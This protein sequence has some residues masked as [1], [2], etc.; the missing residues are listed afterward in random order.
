LR[1]RPSEKHSKNIQKIRSLI[2]DI[3]RYVDNI[4][5]IWRYD[6]DELHKFFI[7]LNNQHINIH[8]IIEENGKLPF[9]DVLVSKKTD[10]RSSSTENQY[11]D[12]YL[13]AEYHQPAQKQSAINSLIQRAFTISDKEHLQIE[14]NHLK[15]AYRK[16]GTTQKT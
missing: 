13:R 15:L 2:D 9:L 4:F 6:K 10:L 14:L 1:K 12:R 3:F 5:V 16:T 8:F 7:F 11:T